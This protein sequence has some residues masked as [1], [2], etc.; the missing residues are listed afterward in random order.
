MWLPPKLV[1]APTSEPITL[2]VAKLHCRVDHDDDDVLISAYIKAAR[3]HIEKRCGIAIV[4]QTLDLQCTDFIDLASLPAGPVTSVTSIKH[5]DTEGAEQTIAGTVYDVRVNGMTSSAVLKFNQSWPS[6]QLGSLI[7]LRAVCGV[8]DSAVDP[9]ITAA[10][11]L[12]V[13][14]WYA[15]REAVSDGGEMPIPFGVAD[16]IENHRLFH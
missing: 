11:L 5:V 8:A 12:L 9:E 13:G 16:L 14:H 6:V 3:A 2:A 15:S 10:M 7:T 4:T 1:T